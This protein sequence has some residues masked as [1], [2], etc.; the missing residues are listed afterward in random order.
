MK[1]KVNNGTSGK[2]FVLTKWSPGAG[3]GLWHSHNRF[4]YAVPVRSVRK[5]LYE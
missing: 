4:N 5:E 1:S 2:C 3:E